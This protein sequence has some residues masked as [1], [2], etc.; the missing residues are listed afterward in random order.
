[1]KESLNLSSD[2]RERILRINEM[3]MRL[4]RISAWLTH[5]NTD[6]NVIRE[7]VRILD[8]Y[9]RSPLWR[10]DF[11]ADEAGK[12]PKELSRGVLSEDGIFNV[13]EAY[14]ETGESR[15]IRLGNQDAATVLIQMV[16]D[17][18]LEGIGYELEEI[19]KLTGMD[20]CLTAIKVGCWNDDLS[21]WQAPAV[22]GMEG[23]GGGARKTLEMLLPYC[24][25]ADKNYY[26]GGYSLAGLF[27]LWAACQTDRFKGV[28]AASPSIWFPG[29]LDYFKTVTPHTG[30]VYLSLGDKEE[31]TRNSVMAQSGLRIREA[32]GCLKERG[33]ECTLEWN[34]GNHFQDAEKRTARAFAWL[35]EKSNCT[36][37]RA[38]Y[39]MVGRTDAAEEH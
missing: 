23:F 19:T 28:A 13:L 37:K 35:M 6:E 18:G 33:M 14:Q 29:F 4:N 30:Y 5:F 34:P 27:A 20:F 24:A 26:I 22:F 17:H 11:E 16:D 31:K 3:D 8:E 39:A 1:M 9:Y 7:D 25:E 12:L 10:S 21:P 32:Y 38:S 36:T 2:L 15:I